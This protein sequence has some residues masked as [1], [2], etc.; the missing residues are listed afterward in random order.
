MPRNYT[1]LLHDAVRAH[2]VSL[3][4]RARE[5]LREKL[6]F[7]QAGLWDTGVRV[8]KLK[9]S[10]RAVFEAR[11]SRGDRILFTL[12]DP[13]AGHANGGGVTRIYV[14]GVVKHDDVTA[15]AERRIV[16]ANAP[17][18]DFEPV[19]IEELPEFVADDLGG[20]YFSPALDQPVAVRAGGGAAGDG[21]GALDAGPQRWLVVDDQEWR[22]LLAAQH[23]DHLELYLFLTR[24]QARL[25]HSEPPLLLSG[26]AGSGK[27][28]I[29]VYFL[30]RH[31][32]RRLTPAPEDATAPSAPDRRAVSAGPGARGNPARAPA[33]ASAPGTPVPASA[34]SSPVPAALHGAA[35]TGPSV[36]GT[37]ARGADGDA[38]RG[39]AGAERALFLTCSAHLKR[40][41]ERIYRGLVKA[42]ELEH[43]PEAVRFATLGELL[44][45]ILGHA[46]RPEWQAAPAGLAE[47]GAILR[48]HPGAARYDTELVWEEIR[49]IIKG[50]KPPVSRRRFAEL[51][52]RFAAAQALARER[53]ELAEYVVRLANLEAG[54]K[55]DGVRVRNTA[56]GSLEEFAVSLRDGLTVRRRE[57]LFLLD[58]A[59]RFLDKQSARLD[60]PLLTLREY[61]GLGHKRAPNFPFD[62]RDI[63]RI[64]EY[65]QKRLQADARYDEIDQTRAAL[66]YLERHG[67]RFRYDLV[68]CDE[69]QDFTD[70]QLALLFRLAGDPR[71]TVLTGDP[72][73]IIN[74]SGF[75][76]EEVRARY[77]ERG[78]PVPPVIDLSI[79]FRSVGNIVS[80]ANEV[81]LLKRS[82]IG[83]ASGEIAERWTFRGRPPLL[84]DGLAE[85]GMLAAIRRGGAGQVVLVRTEAER[86]RL[87]AALQS[88]L[89][90]TIGEA[91]GLEF[92]A[93]LLWRFPTALGSAAIWRRIAAGRVR[94]AADAP[95]IRHELNLLYVAVTRA[96][97]TLLIWDGEQVSPIWGIDALAGQV[98]RSADAADIDNLWQRVS[99]PAEWR[100]Q[101]DYFMERERFAAA[102]ECY[103]NAQAA[104]E[105]EL[106]RAHRLEREGALQAAA[107]L[108]VRLGRLPRAAEGLERAAAFPDAAR[109]WRRAGNEM[110][111]MACEAKQAEAAGDYAAAAARW[112]QLGVEEGVLRNWQRGGDFGNLA[113][114]YLD[115][116]VPSEA[117]RYLQRIGDHARAAEQFRRAGMLK[118][119]AA[120]YE[121]A[122]DHERAALLYRRG[123]DNDGLL[124]SLLN[125]G[126]FH[127]AGLLHE[128]R[129]DLEQAADCFLRHA[130]SSPEARRDLERELERIAG[131]HTGMR[132]AIRM[133]A[134]GQP[135]RAAPIYLEHGHPERAAELFRAAGQ[136]TDAARCLAE[137][138][139]YREAA[140]EVLRGSE[141]G[142]FAAAEFLLQYLTGDNRMAPDRIGEL[143]RTARRLHRG[144]EYE[145]ALA[146]YLAL[147]AAR[148]DTFME[149]VVACCDKLEKHAVAIEYCL[150]R[151]RSGEAS[152]YL[153]ARPD[154]VLLAP[155]VEALVRGPGDRSRLASEYEEAHGVLFRLMHGCLYRGVLTDRRERMAALLE[156]LPPYYGMGCPVTVELTDLIVDLRRYDVIIDIALSLMVRQPPPGEL[157]EYFRSRLQRTAD[158]EHDPELAL[159]LLLGDRPAYDAGLEAIEVNER[160]AALFAH[161]ARHYGVAVEFHLERGDRDQAVAVCTN[162][163]DFARAGHLHEQGGDLAMAADAYADGGRLNDALR[164]YREVGDE[165]GMARIH[166]RQ[167]RHEQALAIWRR[168]GREQ[169][170]ERVR[171]EMARRTAEREH[172]PG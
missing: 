33:R 71:R 70:M 5:R 110:R 29:A 131:R 127:A 36:P 88:E 126:L 51:A 112:Q 149:G 106:A 141:A 121:L 94:G 114:F 72:K 69:V 172:P 60:Q 6:E 124:R 45:E 15:A 47:F 104:T 153:D 164:C 107:A 38:G 170:A 1:L 163:E 37:P 22:R 27:T 136:H 117:A 111:A 19:L 156:D 61:E 165:A 12:G 152:A 16:P 159:C 171:R 4:A 74:P 154:L 105:E 10:G 7:L 41:S 42:T 39:P 32:V 83:V 86:D 63:H 134:V 160:N 23:G 90:F 140:R 68:V 48:N 137:C 11:L 17:F 98:Y 133:A 129:G 108:F 80:L 146:H 59:R 93:V 46:G 120:E 25:L 50:A 97:N 9:G 65:Y 169:D 24:E 116:K 123:G 151:G 155:D 142:A 56:F 125:A 21:D 122:G 76:W 101:G 28:T 53:A 157:Q 150:H 89:V 2:L 30:L 118:S 139:R 132:A 167:H 143:T 57:Q 148:G 99:T 84:V 115:R 3:D 113:Q 49:S 31:R 43:T 58:A 81:L 147:G 119:A 162:H 73:Q 64:A 100:A 95:H 67:D 102:E 79:N 92:D 158:Q 130:E 40:F 166:E 55:L 161:S 34:R 62:R 138:G 168:L 109:M 18:L 75:R 77:Y 14:W 35:G 144:A 128:K 20:D 103:R 13:P 85:A 87:R 52:A 78:L 96:R 66:Q 145:L 82:M 91:K 26:T 54:A 135:A 44:S 8:K